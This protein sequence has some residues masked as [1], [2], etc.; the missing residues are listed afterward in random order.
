MPKSCLPEMVPHFTG[1]KK[2]CEEITGHLTSKSPRIV[3]IW[4]SP[5]F[6]K[7][8]VAIAVGHHLL[9]QGLAVNY[10]SLRGLQS[11]AD[12]ASKLLSLFGRSVASDQQ[13]QQ[14]LSIDDELFQLFSEM[15][16]HCTIILDN[17]DELL[18]GGPKVKED[19]IHF[20]ADILRRTE[21]VT[22]VIATRESL[23]FMKVQFQGLQAIR[24]SSLDTSSSQNLVHELLPNVTTSDRKQIT[25]ICGHIPLAIKLLCPFIFEDDDE[26]NQVLNDF[27]EAL[28][29]HNIVEM[30]DSPDYPSNLTLKLLFTSSFQR[31]SAEEKEALVSLSALPE[32]F[33]LTVAAIVLDMPQTLTKKILLN[34]ERKSLLDSSSTPRLF[35]MHQLIRSFANQRGEHEMKE[36]ILRSRALLCAFYVSRFGKLNEKFLTGDSM[37]AFIDFYE[38]EQSITQSLLEGCTDSK[39]ANSVFKVLVEAELFLYSLYWREGSK[40]NKIYD[41][42]LEGARRLNENASIRQLLVSKALYQVTW[43]KKGNTEQL[44]SEAMNIEASCSSVPKGDDKGKRLCYSGIYQLVNGQTEAGIH[45]LEE[46]FSLMNGSAEKSILKNIAFQILA[47]NDRFKNNSSGTSEVFNKSIQEYQSPGTTQLLIIPPM[48]HIRKKIEENGITQQPLKLEIISLVS[49]A[50]KQFIDI[51]TKGSTIDAAQEIKNSIGKSAVQCSL[52]SFV[53]QCNVNITLQYVM[54]KD[55]GAD[56]ISCHE[57]AVNP[58]KRPMTAPAQDTR[59]SNKLFR[60]RSKQSSRLRRPATADREQGSRL[61][62]SY[63]SFGATQHEEEDLQSREKALDSRL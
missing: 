36:T 60:P 63:H 1:R 23:E 11:K 61:A 45:S 51:E 20:L 46:A 15:S 7:T 30:L 49:D 3:S 39:T 18:S 35:S 16:D 55:E 6:G 33:D 2:E 27:K 29:N 40:F 34:L 25:E 43:R 59:T 21:K 31:L 47:T 58:P 50:T 4:G 28:D 17:A 54:R 44:L 10:L 53:F 37:S 41:S 8:S 26:P 38:E 57:T 14:R 32:S 52:G 22:F 48:G 62:N 19:F 9:S 13:T 5:G 24:I 42:A 12:L 56:E